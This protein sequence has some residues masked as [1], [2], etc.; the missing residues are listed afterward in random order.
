MRIALVVLSVLLLGSI[1]FIGY[2]ILDTAH[3]QSD[4]ASQSRYDRAEI[5][6]LRRLATALA[7]GEPARAAVVKA[8]ASE[9]FEKDGWIVAGPLMAKISGDHLVKVCGSVQL[10]D[11]RCLETK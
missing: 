11:D 5:M 10:S 3:W 4:E 8:G 7:A 2:Q 9:P 6:A 1:A